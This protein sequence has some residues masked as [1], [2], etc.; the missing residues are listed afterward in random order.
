MS[1]PRP[2]IP[3]H[4]PHAS[5]TLGNPPQLLTS[6]HRWWQMPPWKQSGPWQE[7]DT[8]TNYVIGGEICGGFVYKG[9][10][11]V[12][13]N[14]QEAVQDPELVV[15]LLSHVRLFETPWTAACPVS[16]S[17]TISWSLLKL[18]S[19]ESVMPSH[20]F[21]LCCSLLLLPSIF[22]SIRVF[23]ISSPHQVAKV[24]E[25]WHQSFQ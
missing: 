7:K 2:S 20:H 4:T 11:R 21:I 12:K 24:L 14:Q 9:V 18:M 17:F 6:R 10:V 16:L 25:L 1:S 15:Q 22:P 8:H 13:G 19:M 23:L 5:R 3:H